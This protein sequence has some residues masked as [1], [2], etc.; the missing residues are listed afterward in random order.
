M[1]SDFPWSSCVFNPVGSREKQDILKRAF[2]KRP[3]RGAEGA[4]FGSPFFVNLL[5][6]EVRKLVSDEVDKLCDEK[7]YPSNDEKKNC[8]VQL[9][10]SGENLQTN[11]RFIADNL[12]K[13]LFFKIQHSTK[14]GKYSNL[15]RIIVT[16]IAA[17]L[18][19]QTEAVALRSSRKNWTS[20]LSYWGVF[21]ETPLSID[22]ASYRLRG[23]LDLNMQLRSLAW[24][25]NPDS[26]LTFSRLFLRRLFLRLSETLGFFWDQACRLAEGSCGGRRVKPIFIF[27]RL[28]LVQSIVFW[29]TLHRRRE[30]NFCNPWLSSPLL[31]V[32]EIVNSAILVFLHLFNISFITFEI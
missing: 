27:R 18:L 26:L 12:S 8:L 14:I 17:F 13:P 30:C 9:R 16:M 6:I 3:R 28:D 10:Q 31:S 24:S 5:L 15:N 20:M 22:F 2:E 25:S 4:Q 19:G 11:R 1:F 32:V 21:F 23:I 7:V 29:F